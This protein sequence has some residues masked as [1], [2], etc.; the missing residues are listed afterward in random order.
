[1][2][3][4]TIREKAPDTKD[5]DDKLTGKLDISVLELMDEVARVATIPDVP[6]KGSFTLVQFRSRADMTR[7]TAT[8][9]LAKQVDAGLLCTRLVVL[10]GRKTRIWWRD[11]TS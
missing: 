7:H 5:L 2:V 8:V 4:K 9:T 10:S 11:A 6:P 3:D 1:M